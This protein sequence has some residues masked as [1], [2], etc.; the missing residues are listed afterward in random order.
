MGLMRN[1]AKRKRDIY[2]GC[3]LGIY[4]LNGHRGGKFNE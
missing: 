1:Y 2:E 4:R 3:S